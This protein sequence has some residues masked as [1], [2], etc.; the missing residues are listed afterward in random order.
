YTIIA[1][2]F[3]SLT[4]VPW[5]A[6]R[7]LKEGDAAHGN[8]FLRWFERGIHATYAPVLDRALAR[9][10]LTVAI[11]ATLVVASVA[12]VQAVG[13]SLFPKAGTP[14]FLVHIETPEGSSVDG[15]D[16][17]ARFGGRGLARDPHRETG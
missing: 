11:A 4:I 16:R 10:L 3:V 13:F 5:L 9:P 17:A 15:T 12:L 2:L 6:S 7:T 1:S 8:V 14:R